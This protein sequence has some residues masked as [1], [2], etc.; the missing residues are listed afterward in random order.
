VLC[1][2][3][4]AFYHGLWLPDQV[5]IKR[6]A[7]RF[8][9]PIKQHL[10]ERLSAGELP[11]WFPYDGLGRPFIGVAA[12]AVFHPFTALYFLLPAHDAYR[13]STLL[14]CLLGA[15]G[16][17][18]L[19]RALAYSPAGALAAGVAFA[20]SG[21]VVSLTWNI[22]YLYSICALPL[23][24]AALEK[25]LA[26]TR[27]WAVAPAAVWATVFL[28]GDVQTGYYFGFIAL[29]WAAM[30]APSPR[31]EG[32]LRLALAG[33][34]AALLAGV[35]LGPSA[36]VYAGSHLAQ[37]ALFHEQ[38]LYWSTHPLRLVTMLASPI[39]GG[40]NPAEVGRFFFG[41]PDHGMWADSLY[42]GL[43][44]TGLALLGARR[45]RDLRALVFLGVFAL[46]LAL[47]RYGGLYDVFYWTV[48][49]W[50]VFR[51]PEKLMGVASFAVA[52]L[53]G[54]GLDA[55]RAGVGRPGPWLIAAIVCAGAWAG[56][57]IEA[58]GTWTAASFAA[59]VTL[60]HEMT[61][62]AATA[63]LF[64]AVAA[65]GVWLI[66]AGARKGWLREE[67]LLVALVTTLTLDL[68]RANLEF[69]RTAPAEFAT[70]TPLFARE[71]AAREGESTLG[72]F[73]LIS[74]REPG[75]M[76]PTALKPALDYDAGSIERRQALDLE[77]NV[78]FHLE[79]ALEYF[80]G[81]DTAFETMFKWKKSLDTAARFNVTYVIGRS[82]RKGNPLFANELVAEL[83]AYGLALFRNPAPAKPRVYLSRR[84][85]RAASPIDPAALAARPDFQSGELDVIETPEPTLPGPATGGT[86][87]MER[88][89]PEE[90]RVRVHTPQPAVLILLDAYAAGW[91]ATLESGVEVPIRK[92]NAL[93]RAVVVPAGDHVVTFRYETPLLWVGA[94][95]SLAGVIICLALIGE[96]RRRAR[97]TQGFR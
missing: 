67:L 5:L 63:F 13:V 96:A 53:A 49:L 59:P 72:R 38:A 65:G 41:N 1:V 25:A 88:Y 93:V 81:Y 83:P 71:I 20:L 6:D 32:F 43:P 50:S 64:S 9:L 30:R 97:A 28:N 75:F 76:A 54:A 77:H 74:I 70:F 10:V 52:M 69:Y 26:A 73:R 12:T 16:A 21:Y 35:Q 19:G 80:P 62:S 95:A 11:Q 94:G 61:G 45:R 39:G 51:Y 82:A 37:P 47:G 58:V 34:L 27:A 29:L 87:K 14:S 31:R 33:G 92:A 44:M 8:H 3:T 68:S 23:F 91:R 15:L 56:L 66:V 2:V 48:P 4:L 86:V 46:L 42:L 22:H 18:A 60:A 55:L 84:P 36:M 85:E 7:Y 89:A 57:R 78:E 17:F 24:C 79:A 40:V 90:V